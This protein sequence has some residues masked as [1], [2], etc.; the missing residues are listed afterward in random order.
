MSGSGSTDGGVQSRQVDRGRES[1]TGVGAAGR[2][3]PEQ[4]LRVKEVSME[5]QGPAAL[6]ESRKQKGTYSPCHINDEQ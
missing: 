6:I 5:T 1:D 3:A 4:G 2:G